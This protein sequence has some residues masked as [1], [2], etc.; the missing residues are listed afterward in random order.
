MSLFSTLAS[1]CVC[2]QWAQRMFVFIFIFIILRVR[3]SCL[4]FFFSF[5]HIH[6]IIGLRI[7][8]SVITMSHYTGRLQTHTHTH[9]LSTD[10]LY[11]KYVIVMNYMD[12][13]YI[14]IFLFCWFKHI[15]YCVIE[16]SLLPIR[17]WQFMSFIDKS[18]VTFDHDENINEF[19]INVNYVRPHK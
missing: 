5:F 3:G 13:F 1:V 8:W 18:A 12:A 15:G 2:V 17:S 19:D 11:E 7:V 10:N 4:L 9:M 16:S 14:L 6:Y